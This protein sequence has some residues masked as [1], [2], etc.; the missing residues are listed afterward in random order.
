M[1]L[2]GAEGIQFYLGATRISLR[3]LIE[4][5]VSAAVVLVVALWISAAVERQMIHGTGNDLSVRK[6]AANLVR[7][8]L[9]T[10]GLLI[11][12]SAVGIDLTA[13]S[14]LG[15]A[16]GVGL[17]FGLQRIAVNYVGGFV[18]LAE[19]A[20]RVGD[21]IRVDGFE[22]R[23]SD[24]R[25]RYTVVRALNGRESIVPN[26]MF[27]SQRVENLSY[28]DS[29]VLVQSSV[30]VPFGTDVR[31]LQDKM[32]AVIASIPR[33][34][35]DPAP[36]I[37]LSAFGANGLELAINFWIDDPDKGQGNV[38]SEVNLAV[39]ELL[40]SEGIEVPRAGLLLGGKDPG[41]PLGTAPA[42]ADAPAGAGGSAPGGRV[43]SV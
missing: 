21:V 5:S 7:A 12:L 39:L 19:R 24:I 20:V 38:K 17:G 8:V 37:Q 14:V 32:L 18:M 26:E 33:V 3:N 1:L 29:R 11:A 34:I 42:A 31:A 41:M 43:N 22:G 10:V 4:G 9:M 40:N 2:E 30:V 35:A 25:A 6:M 13:L 27:I 15:G 36:G 28:A 16:L 23:V